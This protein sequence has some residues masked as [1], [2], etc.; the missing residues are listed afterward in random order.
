[1]RDKLESL[2]KTC[3]PQS[4]IERVLDLPYAD[5]EIVSSDPLQFIIQRDSSVM[6]NY[7][8]LTVAIAITARATRDVSRTSSPSCSRIGIRI[9]QPAFEV[10]KRTITPIVTPSL[11]DKQC[12]CRSLSMGAE[13]EAQG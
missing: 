8:A 4:D 13:A 7:H 5:C 11:N 2:N 10:C 12:R 6:E 3:Q 1:M 9:A